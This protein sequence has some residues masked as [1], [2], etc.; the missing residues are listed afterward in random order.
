M[1]RI[2]FACLILTL[3]V[4]CTDFR[5]MYK[6]GVTRT[7]LNID[8]GACNSD[9]AARYPPRI[10]TDWVPVFNGDGQVISHRVEQYDINEARRREGARSCMIAGGYEWATI[11]FC[12]EE[13]IAGR[14]FAPI[15]TL[16]ALSTNICGLRTD[17]GRVLV[18][19]SK[20]I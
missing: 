9:A 4:G 14:S 7:Q 16:P 17:S 10:V 15:S 1:K 19:L 2:A 3:V 18:D 5:Q 11:P 13:Q 20:P 8:Q 12:K 6:P